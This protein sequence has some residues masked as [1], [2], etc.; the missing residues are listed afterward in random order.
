M[1][2]QLWSPTQADLDALASKTADNTLTSV[3]GGP[4][5]VKLMF[6]VALLTEMVG[7]GRD[8]GIVDVNHPFRGKALRCRLRAWWRLLARTGHFQLKPRGG[9]IEKPATWEALYEA[10]VLRWGGKNRDGK[11][12]A[13]RVEVV[14]EM[15]TKESERVDG[16]RA[17]PGN[18]PGY[19]VFAPFQKVDGKPSPDCFRKFG[20]R[21]SSAQLTIICAADIE[22]EVL[23]CLR[24]WASFDGFGARTRRGAGTVM[25]VDARGVLKPIS[26]KDAAKAGCILTARPVRNDAIQ[27]W[28]E[29]AEKLRSFRQGH[30]HTDIRNALSAVAQSVSPSE[31]E[32][33]NLK[34]QLDAAVQTFKPG[35][36]KAIDESVR[37]F[38]E[39]KPPQLKKNKKGAIVWNVG[40]RPGRSNWPEPDMIR[41]AFGTHAPHHV[42]R[43]DRP[44]CFPRAVLGLPFVGQFA[45]P[46]PDNEGDP[47]K[48][49]VLPEQGERLASSIIV[50]PRAVA[51]G[52]YEA[53]A[54]FVPPILPLNETDG[55]PAPQGVSKAALL[56]MRV[57]VKTQG[58]NGVDKGDP[59]PV[60]NKA[61][62]AAG[63]SVPPVEVLGTNTAGT[64]AGDPIS[65]FLNYF[66]K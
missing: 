46:L 17:S 15:S 14:I 4:E 7:G 42:P 2:T 59:V 60:W 32:R 16:P 29:C 65:A 12:V 18:M 50:K 51:D 54:L 41:R 23:R 33:E 43:D 34:S 40:Y 36:T 37:P 56:A 57:Q 63:K 53:I 11:P 13:G 19:V 48:F 31:S 52:R 55:V 6:T 9:A 3:D 8:K 38:G 58:D 64:P 24:W 25:V 45:H 20:K 21:D 30:D 26:I 28:Q 5:V 35:G 39:L 66:V 62:W 61:N 22:D 1:K 44:Q 47:G 49:Q 27:A 10:E